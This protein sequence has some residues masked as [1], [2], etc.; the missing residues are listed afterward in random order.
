MGCQGVDVSLSEQALHL[1]RYGVEC[2][3]RKSYA[4]YEDFQQ[5]V[6]NSKERVP[7]LV[8]KQNRSRPLAVLDL[9]HFMELVRGNN[10]GIRDAGG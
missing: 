7:L 3:S 4:I 2:K 10:K 1:F 9:D 6:E 5:A 8:I